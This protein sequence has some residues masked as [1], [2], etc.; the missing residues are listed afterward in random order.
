MSPMEKI[1]SSTQI[2]QDLYRAMAEFKNMRPW[3]WMHDDDVFAVQNPVHG[4]LGYCCIM[5]A[6]GEVFALGV[7]LGSDGLEIYSRIQ[8]GSIDPEE[9]FY[10]QR[11]LLASFEDR[12]QLSKPDLD[13]IKSLGLKFRGRNSWPLLRSYLPGY[14]P[15][16]L[17]DE[18][19]EYLTLAL[20]QTLEVARRCKENNNLLKSKLKGHYFVRVPERAGNTLTWKDAWLKPS[21]LPQV[22]FLAPQP[23]IIRLEK[24]NQTAPKRQGLWEIDVFYAPMVVKEHGRPYYPLMVMG[25]IQESGLLFMA[26]VAGHAEYKERFQNRFIEFLETANHL[27]EGLLVGK[28]EVRKLFE[29]VASRLKIKMKIVSRLKILADAK[30]KLCNHFLSR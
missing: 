21:S 17:T 3:E 12:D 5:G 7:Y 4:E 29:P 2:W 8:S 18:E 26:E 9:V 28:D 15:W 23:D 16:Y 30:T 22:E 11:V 19:A 27:P 25:A 20:Q 1:S 13:Q 14:H 6:L 10:N 24:I